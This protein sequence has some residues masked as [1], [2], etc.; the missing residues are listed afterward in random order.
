MRSKHTKQTKVSFFW[1]RNL[2]LFP[3]HHFCNWIFQRWM[4]CCWNMLGGWKTVSTN[5]RTL[6]QHSCT[7]STCFPTQLLCTH[8]HWRACFS[9]GNIYGFEQI[10]AMYLNHVFCNLTWL[11][12]Y[13]VSTDWWLAPTEKCTTNF[14]TIFFEIFM[15]LLCGKIQACHFP[16]SL[17][18]MGYCECN[19]PLSPVHSKLVRLTMPCTCI[20]QFSIW[21]QPLVLEKRGFFF[22]SI[23]NFDA[24][25]ACL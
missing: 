12:N 8:L 21:L 22:S 10:T 16:N 20:R 15:C 23:W 2:V 18:C 6:C 7:W 4:K 14:W 5:S 13:T 25:L 17:K 3:M 24:G 19:Q 1:R 9:Y 11:P